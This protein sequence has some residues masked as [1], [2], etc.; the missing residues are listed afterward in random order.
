MDSIL[1]QHTLTRTYRILDRARH[2]LRPHTRT[3]TPYMSIH[4]ANGHSVVGLFCEV[5]FLVMVNDN[6]LSIW[7]YSI[8]R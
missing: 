8:L 7:C 1:I 3:Y 2:D 4:A 5:A 6:N